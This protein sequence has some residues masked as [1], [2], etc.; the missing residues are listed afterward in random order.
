MATLWI[1][2]Y[3]D[4]GQSSDGDQIPIAAEPGRDQTVTFTTST[5]S[6][7]F[8]GTT[9]FIAFRASADF[10]YKVGETPVATTSSLKILSTELLFIGVQPGHKIAAVTG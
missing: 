4:I 3:A 9:R 10:H 1:R 7:A 8:A 2:E 6:A 5:A